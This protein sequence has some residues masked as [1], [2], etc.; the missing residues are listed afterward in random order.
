MLEQVS[1]SSLPPNAE[2]GEAR[3]GYVV[4][5]SLRKNSGEKMPLNVLAVVPGA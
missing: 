4:L 1:N 5:L 3:T 2:T